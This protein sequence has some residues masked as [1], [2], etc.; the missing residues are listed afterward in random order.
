[1]SGIIT[2]IQIATDIEKI[3]LKY[4]WLSPGVHINKVYKMLFIAQKN[5]GKVCQCGTLALLGTLTVVYTA[6]LKT[7]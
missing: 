2:P 1:M 3:L 6:A 5:N 7:F 4:F